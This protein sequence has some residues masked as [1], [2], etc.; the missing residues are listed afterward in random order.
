MRR[1]VKAD[2]M[3]WLA[4]ALSSA[5]RY[6]LQ[7]SLHNIRAKTRG[8]SDLVQVFVNPRDPF[9]LPLLQA[10]IQLQERFYVRFRVHT[11]WQLDDNMYPSRLSGAPGRNRTLQGSHNYT[12][13]RLQTGRRRPPRPN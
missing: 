11:V 2:V 6:A 3:P 8:E 13:S 7:R 1:P 10:L 4:R 9:G 12:A 5:P